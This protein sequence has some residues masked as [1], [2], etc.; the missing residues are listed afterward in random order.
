M[1][2]KTT[3]LSLTMHGVTTTVEFPYE[4]V[5][6]EEIFNAFK[7]VMVGATFSQ[8]QYQNYIIELGKIFLEQ[9]NEN[10]D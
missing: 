1:E 3:K 8:S 7:A 10:D 5:D 4:D 6:L 2:I 9:K